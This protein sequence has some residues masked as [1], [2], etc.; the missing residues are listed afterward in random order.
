MMTPIKGHGLR[1]IGARIK[2]ASVRQ[3]RFTVRRHVGAVIGAGKFVIV[4]FF[5]PSGGDPQFAPNWKF[6]LGLGLKAYRIIA[7]RLPR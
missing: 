4:R 6:G 5:E 3:V 2:A 7:P 1:V